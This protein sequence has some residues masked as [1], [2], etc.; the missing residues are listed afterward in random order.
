MSDVDYARTYI[1]QLEKLTK[2]EPFPR[3][4]AV[5]RNPAQNRIFVHTKTKSRLNRKIY[6]KFTYIVMV[7]DVMVE[8]FFSIFLVIKQ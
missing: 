5:T 4:L 3:Y 7:A 8:D 1:P 6:V 2:V